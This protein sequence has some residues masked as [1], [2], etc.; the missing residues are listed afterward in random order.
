[1]SQPDARYFT[2][3]PMVLP[4]MGAA[5]AAAASRRL[6]TLALRHD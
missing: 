6:G 3:Y 1:M 5:T 4:V 2:A